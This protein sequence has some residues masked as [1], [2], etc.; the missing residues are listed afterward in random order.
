[1]DR[2]TLRRSCCSC[3]TLAIFFGILLI[4]TA[5]LLIY[6]FRLIKKINIT[7][8]IQPSLQAKNEFFE[9]IKF[10]QEKTPT[11]ELRIT[12]EEMTSIASGGFSNNYFETR[13][14][15]IQ[16][17]SEG[18][19]IF[20]K[21]IKPLKT[22]LKIESK[23]EVDKGQIHFKFNKISAGKLGLPGL[24]KSEIEQAFNKMMDE[25]FK[26]LYQY[27]QVEK[28]ELKEDEMIIYGQIKS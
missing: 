18:I 13:E 15:Q 4:I 17:L 27:Y 26:D 2:K 16:I 10:D 5:G 12:S 22:D 3:K 23:P 7:E 20:G 24:L 9:K 14:V 25:N 8:N 11:L 6:G 19:E 28:I 1:M 21:M